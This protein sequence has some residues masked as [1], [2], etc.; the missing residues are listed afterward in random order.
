MKDIFS[1]GE[2]RVSPRQPCE[3]LRSALS[4]ADRHDFRKECYISPLSANYLVTT[5]TIV[6][7]VTFSEQRVGIRRFHR[8]FDE[9][10]A[11]R[12]GPPSRR[13]FNRF[14]LERLVPGFV[15]ALGEV[16]ATSGGNAL[17]TRATRQISI[18]AQIRKPVLGTL[19]SRRAVIRS[20]RFRYPAF[21][22]P[23]SRRRRSRGGTSRLGLATNRKLSPHDQ[24]RSITLPF[25]SANNIVGIGVELSRCV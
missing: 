1:N 6:S 11:C 13:N 16:R 10:P 15:R 3:N 21:C 12:V 20:S 19:S 2:N 24:A 8:E 25:H 5:I 4:R 23:T 18:R 22:L 9:F 14:R 17:E 7:N